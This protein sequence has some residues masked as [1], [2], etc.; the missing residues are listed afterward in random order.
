M[1]CRSAH[2]AVRL[3]PSTAVD[4]WFMAYSRNDVICVTMTG[5]LQN[6]AVWV[7]D[8]RA[9]LLLSCY[10]TYALNLAVTVLSSLCVTQTAQMSHTELLLIHSKNSGS[11]FLKSPNVVF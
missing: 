4:D 1:R 9:L 10:C 3:L 5:N 6:L 8:L 11:D 7:L 2:S